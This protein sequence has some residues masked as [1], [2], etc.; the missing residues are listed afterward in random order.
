MPYLA[1]HVVG[2]AVVFPAA[3]F[4]EMALAASAEVAPAA[5]S[6]TIENMEIRSPLLLSDDETKV[7]QLR[8]TGSD[9]SFQI[10]SRPRLAEQDW[11]VHVQGRLAGPSTRQRQAPVDIHS[12]W[13]RRAEVVRPALHYARTAA[14]GLE[15]GPAFQAV[16]EARVGN[17]E[18]QV[19]LVVPE[20]VADGLSEYSLHPSLLD[21][22]LQSLA[23]A[24]AADAGSRTQELGFLPFQIGKMVFYGDC[25]TARF[26]R[27]FI[28]RKSAR[29]ILANFTL[30]DASGSVVAELSNF[31]FRR[32]RLGRG[33]RSAATLLSF[34]A[35]VAVRA[36]DQK[37]GMPLAP[38]NLAEGLVEDLAEQWY[39]MRR[40]DHYGQVLPLF[41]ALVA[42][43][44]FRAISS[45]GSNSNSF[46]VKELMRAAGVPAENEAWLTR[47]IE[48]LEE[49]R[50]VSR[51]GDQ[52]TLI[53]GDD[54]VDPDEIWRLLLADFPGYLPEIVL[55]GRAGAHL[56]GL[57]TG[58]YSAK[59]LLSNGSQ[60][61]A[62]D[63]LLEFSPALRIT[64]CAARDVLGAIASVWPEN[65][66]IRVLELSLGAVALTAEIAELLPQGRSSYVL[67]CDAE[68]APRASAGLAD[69]P[70]VEVR[71]VTL[72][73]GLEEQGFELHGFDVI[74][75]THV[76]HTVENPRA[77]LASLR[78]LMVVDGLLIGLE[79]PAERLSDFIF[80][81]DPQWWSRSRDPSRPQPKL[82]AC[83]EWHDLMEQTGFADAVELTEP[84]P[85]VS[86]SSYLVIARNPDL[87]GDAGA[88]DSERRVLI[89]SDRDGDTHIAATELKAH[90]KA[91][92]DGVLLVTDGDEFTASEDAIAL[93][94]LDVAHWR[95]LFTNLAG[96]NALCDEIVFLCGWQLSA[97]T[98][99]DALGG[100]PAKA[101]AKRAGALIHI[102][103]AVRESGPSAA[104][105]TPRVWVVGSGSIGVD[106]INCGPIIPSQAPLRGLGR[107]LENEYPDVAWKLLDIEATG[108]A[109]SAALLLASEVISPDNEDEV[110]RT[111]EARYALRAERADLDPP[112]VWRTPTADEGVRLD[113]HSPGPLTNLSWRSEPP[114]PPGKGEIQIQVRA[115]GLNF[116]DVMYAMGMLSDEAVENGFAGA[117]LG[118]ECAGDIIAVGA[119]VTGFEVGDP[120]VCF[121]RACFASHVTTAT[122]AVAHKPRGWNYSEAATIPSVFFTVYYALHH[123]AHLQAGEKI[124]IHGAAGGVGLAAIQYARF[125][126]A[127]IFATAGSDEKRDF[128]RLLGVEHILDSRS[129][130][131]ADEIMDITG[132]AGVDVVLNSLSGEAVL[133]NFDVLK[134]FGRFLELGKRDFYE[135]AKIGL[136]PFRNNITYYGIDADQLLVE[137]SDLAGRL[138][139]EMMTLFEQGAFRPLVHL[140]FP[141]SRVADA[142]RH[143][144]QSRHIGKIIV[145]FDD[146]PR[147]ESKPE[148]KLGKLA[149]DGEACYLVTG[150]FSGFGLASAAWLGTKGARHIALLGRTAPPAKRHRWALPHSKRAALRSTP[151]PSMSPILKTCSGH[152]HHLGTPIHRSKV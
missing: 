27:L 25:D 73:R 133:K 116:R 113:F 115:T 107:V 38:G 14:A 53:A 89:I 128:L 135:N 68:Q 56:P 146:L 49:D 143:M 67:A 101:Q 138:F 102:A 145:N 62:A 71:E 97:L 60:S 17:E 120:V 52:F 42:G 10:R 130:A 82:R 48:V 33:S 23:D 59:A 92:G 125:C 126:G 87:V 108:E 19:S 109:H 16:A 26:C 85:D 35:E 118:M 4:V 142:F 24:L 90:L 124:L 70:Q 127:E 103:Q 96:A 18:T 95:R 148:A 58:D 147:F 106:G 98:A 123:L 21:A 29:S 72:S 28:S 61:S 50:L 84:A 78:K 40:A 150:G 36:E 86:A 65:R 91:N 11:A 43:Y 45:L 32:M 93:D 44:A 105:N 2:G 69:C 54:V 34:T 94:I 55:A 137:R 39:T 119:D 47:L 79:R 121:A 81:A 114:R 74:L 129:L 9:R 66:R 37:Q 111:S 20:S 131:F 104:G 132:G 64:E 13:N 122:T 99:S 140:E 134:P 83:E 3:G 139:R 77:L 76:L 136:R 22:C 30:Y 117:T 1:D 100:P 151:W 88:E 46:N 31:R 152:W 149:L 51:N 110:I 75:V 5:T 41:D 63:K 57:I 12:N 6:H 8:L 15:Y 112:S 7:V 144:Q 80:G 141:C